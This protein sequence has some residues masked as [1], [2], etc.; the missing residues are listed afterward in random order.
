MTGVETTLV[1]SLIHVT[2][3]EFTF[4]INSDLNETFYTCI[5]IDLFNFLLL[6]KYLQS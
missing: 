1:E 6:S 4:I 5:S 2:Q 3:G